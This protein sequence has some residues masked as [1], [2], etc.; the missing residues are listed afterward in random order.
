MNETDEPSKAETK[1]LKTAYVAGVIDTGSTM[2]CRING[3]ADSRFNYKVAL[4]IRLS[5][6]LPFTIG[7]I[8]DWCLDRGIMTNIR[9][10]DD[11]YY[12]EI[13]RTEDVRLVVEAILPYIQDHY[14]AFAYLVDELIPYMDNH[15]YKTDRAEFIEVARR[16]ETFRDLH[17]TMG[18]MK[19]D[20]SYFEDEWSEYL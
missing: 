13:K 19:Y 11:R 12:L 5:R 14:D 9:E 8:D 4:D 3:A 17:P 1:R 2:N 6:A 7:F 18:A 20:A 15:D 16:I 10:G